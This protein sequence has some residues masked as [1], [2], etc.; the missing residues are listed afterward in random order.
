VLG[1]PAERA[2]AD[3][4]L[5]LRKLPE[6]RPATPQE[7]GGTIFVPHFEAMADE[8]LLVA[9][10]AAGLEIVD[11]RQ[12]SREVIHRLRTARLVVA[13][14]MHAAIIADALRTPW[15]P[16]VSSPAISSFKWL[17]WAMALRVPY[18]PVVLPPSST[19]RALRG[20]LAGLGAVPLF[21]GSDSTA[22]L[23]NYHRMA[24]ARGAP[25]Y[26]QRVWRREHRIDRAA[27]LASALP[28]AQRL[29]HYGDA[30]AANR[31][32]RCFQEIAA[33]EG[34]L[35]DG[36]HVAALTDQLHELLLAGMRNAAAGSG[37]HALRSAG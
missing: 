34:Y 25:G 13:D 17:D 28:G 31:L 33:R 5:L 9:A 35:S 7:R 20:R 37:K 22:A 36:D 29:A 12:D 26:Q 14:S 6:F 4:A 1:L 21:G 18:E 2:V 16:V 11:P 10:S 23:A 27:A 32:T 24:E 15:I 30:R 8:G 3:G 19:G